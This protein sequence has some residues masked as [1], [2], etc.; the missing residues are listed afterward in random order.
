MSLILDRYGQTPRLLAAMFGHKSTEQLLALREPRDLHCRA[1][2]TAEQASSHYDA[3]LRSYDRVGRA[4]RE[5][6]TP[7]DRHDPAR[8]TCKLLG[9]IG[10]HELW[11]KAKEVVVDFS[12]GEALEVK[13]VVMKELQTIMDKVAQENSLYRGCLRLVGSS[14]DQSKI[15]SPD[16][17]DVNLVITP[18]NVRV[19]VKET[20]KES[21][22][23]KGKL[24]M[25]VVDDT[26][27]L[28][29]NK[30]M[31][32]LFLLV[33]KCLTKYTLQDERLS[34]VPPG[35]S[36]TQ[37]G[38]ALAL[39]WQGRKYPL[40]LVGV[41]LVPVLELPW[42]EK[43]I[44]PEFLKDKA[45]TFHVS[46]TADGSWRC[47][48]ALTEAM[49][50]KSLAPIKRL[51]LVMGKVLLSCLKADPWM[52]QDM[53]FHC[54]WFINREWKI[55]APSGFCFK[56]A[57]LRWLEQLGD[58][59]LVAEQEEAHFCAK[60]LIAVFRQLCAEPNVKRG[61]LTPANISAYFG[62]DFEGVKPG[63]G[64]HLIARCLEENLENEQ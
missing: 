5:S 45:R 52:P 13:N 10:V 50:L 37:V 35:L 17:F 29:G 63:E 57:F 1:G 21:A 64:A 12:C 15:Y 24:Q 26:P 39:A 20:P 34:L 33:Q 43:I 48:F 8:V 28:Q 58:E 9:A 7:I 59:E 44:K 38:A 60:E 22:K 53:K 11:Q 25:S 56:N 36:S 3:Y 4:G 55:V 19:D 27:G 51:V 46:N 32:N 18:K 40:L 49:V 42:H 23:L 31:E 2:T 61:H 41:D 14:Q 30:F 54:T 62:G 6:L 16:E 47:S